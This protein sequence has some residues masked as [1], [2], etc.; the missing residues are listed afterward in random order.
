MPNPDA[1]T[2]ERMHH[3]FAVECNNQGCNLTA[4]PERNAGQQQELLQCAYAAAWHW[5][6]M[7]EPINDA[8]ADMLL[9][10]AHAMLGHA[11]VVLPYGGDPGQVGRDAGFH[12]GGV[13]LSGA[14]LLRLGRCSCQ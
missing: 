5:A 1:E 8:R 11:G 7:G 13:L 10:H 6:K 9:A 12:R 2:I 14:G 3:W 4:L